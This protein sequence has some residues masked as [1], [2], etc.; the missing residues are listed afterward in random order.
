M[1]FSSKNQKKVA[2]KMKLLRVTK[3]EAE[4]MAIHLIP[5]KNDDDKRIAEVVKCSKKIR[6]NHTSGTK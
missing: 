5:R 6:L 3:I 1:K 4:P 2:N